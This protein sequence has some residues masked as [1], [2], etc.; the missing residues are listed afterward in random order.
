[1]KKPGLSIILYRY[2][3]ST[4]GDARTSPNEHWIYGADTDIRDYKI[5][6]KTNIYADA[7][8]LRRAIMG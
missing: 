1:M 8:Y 2:L 4:N 5:T 6:D 7:V 3:G